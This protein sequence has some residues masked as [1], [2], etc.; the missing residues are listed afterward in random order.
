MHWREPMLLSAVSLNNLKESGLTD[1]T[2]TLAGI[3]EALPAELPSEMCQGYAIPYRSGKGLHDGF[4][5]VR[6]TAGGTTKY[7]QR[8]GSGSRVYL[9]PRLSYDVLRN[10]S[11]PLIITEGEKKALAAD[12][13]GLNCIGLAG[14]EN[15]RSRKMRLPTSLLTPTTAPKFTMFTIPPGGNILLD[16][17]SEAVAPELIEIIWEGRSVTIV[18]DTDKRP[19]PDVQR[20]AFDLGLWLDAHGAKVTQVHLPAPPETKVGLDDYLLTNTAN[21]VREHIA[22]RPVFPAPLHPRMYI[23][24]KLANKPGREAYTKAARAILSTLDNRGQRYFD[25]AE[26]AFYFDTETRILHEWQT[27]KDGIRSTSF[28]TMLRDEFGIG[29]SDAQVV[30]RVA[31]DFYA[32]QPVQKIVPHSVSTTVGDTFY[33][34]LNDGTLARVTADGIDFLD[35]GTDGILFRSGKVRDCDPATVS[36]HL[37]S[38]RSGARIEL[39]SKTICDLNLQPMYGMTLEETQNWLTIQCYLSPYLNRWRGLMLPFEH[40]IAE[41]NSG[42]STFF[43]LRKGVYSGQPSLDFVPSDRRDLE[44]ALADT[45]FWVVDN[46]SE[47]PRAIREV[48]SDML[49]QLLTDPEPHVSKRMLYTTNQNVSYPIH[50]AFAVTSTGAPFHRADLLQR[51]VE[52]NM[53]QI[54]EQKRKDEWLS[55]RLINRSAWVA[56]QLWAIHRFLA[57]ARDH[58]VSGFQS[59]SRLVHYDQALILMG[60]ALGLTRTQGA[61]LTQKLA[62]HV[63]QTITSTDFVFTAL[64]HYVEDLRKRRKASGSSIDF[65]TWAQGN[66]GEVWSDAVI[67]GRRVSLVRRIWEMQSDI[68]REMGVVLT[69]EDGKIVISLA[70]VERKEAA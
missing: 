68:E 63:R 56:E 40:A 19:N 44:A 69:D 42:K 6:L 8:A 47:V 18:F 32:A 50:C 12:Q 3:R 26:T 33:Y 24:G 45:S 54:T 25:P 4:V 16:T 13:Q 64:A 49:A 48:L 23:A 20:A 22:N 67:F 35:N 46:I 55:D 15:W 27:W 39:W 70:S 7:F 60:Q 10:P 62:G 29:A 66:T 17:M 38:L 52:Y 31:D 36:A 37:S 59:P 11:L 41:A 2:I 14:V 51:S 5:R 65:Q 58:W 57:L 53:K 34:Q 1:E 43:N 61:A 21:D 28:G 9:P 30:S